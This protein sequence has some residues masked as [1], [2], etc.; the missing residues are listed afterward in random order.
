MIDMRY[1]P[2]FLPQV[3]APYEAVMKKLDEEDIGNAMEEIGH[4]DLQPM[5][6]IVFS[7]EVGKFDE[8]EMNPI[9]VSK[10][11][12][13]VDGHHRFLKS[14]MADKPIKCIKVDLNG[15][16]TARVLNKIQDIY[17]YEKQQGF[18][19]AP[20]Q[21]IEEVLGQG[22]INLNNEIDA[23]FE[24]EEEDT[25]Q[26]IDI[27]EMSDEPKGDGCKVIA[28]RQKPIMEDSVIGNFFM[29][30]QQPGFDKYEID[31]ENLLDTNDLGLDVTGKNPTDMLAK[32]WF[33]NV[34]F[35]NMGKSNQHSP[36]KLK[37]KAIVDR[38]KQ[39]GYDGIKYGDMM[40]QG[41]K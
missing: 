5:Q 21:E 13:I 26:F 41:L 15:V 40:V 39:M 1:K 7:H 3:N 34:D 19:E 22:A 8:E 23:G 28:Y 38:A 14:L 29:L 2:Y 10:D 27:V 17:D 32:T 24:T 35:E 31:F 9:W 20:E 37:N 36:D 11:N 16:D 4:E 6:G 30:T 33:P 12:E 25:E 18:E